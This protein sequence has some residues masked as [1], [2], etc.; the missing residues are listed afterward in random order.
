MPDQENQEAPRQRTRPE[1]EG[2]FQQQAASDEVAP[3]ASND[4]S[5]MHHGEQAR[6]TS[7]N[8]NARAEARRASGGV[9]RY[10]LPPGTSGDMVILDTSPGPCFYEHQIQNPQSGKWDIFELC[11][12]ET[13]DCVLCDRFKVSTYIM[14]LSVIDTRPWTRNDGTVVRFQRKLLAVKN[15]QHEQFYNMH[16]INGRDSFR[17]MHLLMTRGEAAQQSSSIGVPNFVTMLNEEQ[18]REAFSHPPVMY[19]GR[20][21]ADANEYLRPLDYARIFRQPSGEDLRAR[22][23]GAAPAGSAADNRAVNDAWNRDETSRDAPAPAADDG[24]STEAQAAAM[25][26]RAPVANSGATEA[27][28]GEG[29]RRMAETDNA[30]SAVEDDEIPF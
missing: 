1:T 14:F 24:R 30:G 27:S 13:D 18:L 4:S 2:G 22:Y 12:R 21:V 9:F 11:P 26:G 17:G 5:W 10:W 8:E 19:N 20:Q 28:E 3:A 25:A 6:R 7:A 23:G 15:P 16:R 29:F